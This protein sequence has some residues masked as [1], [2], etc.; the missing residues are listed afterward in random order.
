VNHYTALNITKLDVLDT[1]PTIKVA[2]GYKD[3]AT[4]EKLES[5]PASLDVLERVE[6]EYKE[7]KGWESVRLVPESHMS[8]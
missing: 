5:F 3:P 4:G 7:F 6:V 8:D 1:F 2:I